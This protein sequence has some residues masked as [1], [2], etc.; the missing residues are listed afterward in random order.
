LIDPWNRGSGFLSSSDKAAR[1]LAQIENSKSLRFKPFQDG[2]SATRAIPL[3][4]QLAAVST[5]KKEFDKLKPV[6][7]Q[8]CR[9]N[10]RGSLLEWLDAALII[11]NDL[12]PK[13]PSLL[14]SG[15]NDGRL[16][17]TD[18]FR[19]RLID[20]FDINTGKPA[21]KTNALLQA[22][23]FAAPAQGAGNYAIGQYAPGVAGGANSTNGLDGKANVN[24]WDF[25]LFMEG[26]VLFA[27][28]ATRRLNNAAA[29]S[30][31][32]ALYAQA[33]GHLSSS[34]GDKAVRGEQW[35]P[36]WAQS[37][38]LGEIRALL[39]EG[40]AQLGKAA[41]K[42]PLEMARA[43]ARLGVA[44]GISA[45]ERYAYM[46]RNGQA[47]FA[48]PLGRWKVAAQPNQNLLADLDEYLFRLHREARSENAS[49]ALAVAVR[50]LDDALLAAAANGSL[51]LHWQNILLAL[52]D[53]ESLVAKMPSDN[54]VGIL[55]GL[56]PKWIDAA[57]DGTPEFRLALAFGTQN[58]IRR[59]FLP[60]NKFGNK[61]EKEAGVSVVCDGRD[62]ITDAI[63]FIDRR[64]VEIGKGSNRH[65]SQFSPRPAMLADISA[66]LDGS[67]DEVRLLSLARA[68]MALDTATLTA[69]AAGYPVFAGRGDYPPDAFALFRL[70]IRPDIFRRLSS[71]DIVAA[72]RMATQNLRAQSI[73]PAIT[74]A[75]GD[76]RRLA[77]SMAFPVSTTT[78]AKLKETITIN[79][80]E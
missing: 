18:N 66:F 77:A 25:V 13:F 26:T 62:F 37:A 43:V 47:N 10:W 3:L 51:P 73:L 6:F 19:Q 64:F 34:S 33:A 44:R 48:V 63:A 32:F 35:F 45:F 30:A 61:L 22:A 67:L 15:G 57:D 2:I 72:A 54:R 29:A 23:L 78:L 58:N 1:N 27:S 21:K 7:I 79:T 17:F 46:E 39:S 74:L 20:L 14:G 55:S 28:A 5:V 68:F 49:N 16:D 12:S 31:P 24:P 11:Q 70:A 42:D 60:L 41:T 36:L 69:S 52:A 50:N 4:N 59:C 65:L 80:K 9:L 56:T 76:A 71:G 75:V 8:H 40:R 38:T 53:C